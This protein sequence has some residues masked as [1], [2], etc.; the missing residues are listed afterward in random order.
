[1]KCTRKLLVEHILDVPGIEIGVENESVG[2]PILLLLPQLPPK[3]QV[4]SVE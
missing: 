1:M 2:S 3:L 4:W